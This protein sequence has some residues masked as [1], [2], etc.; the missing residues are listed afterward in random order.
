MRKIKESRD[1]WAAASLLSD[2]T[3]LLPGTTDLA[4]LGY[5][6]NL[7]EMR[8]ACPYPVTTR[9]PGVKEPQRA[10]E[11]GYLARRHLFV[12]PAWYERMVEIPAA[13]QGSPVA[14][15][16]ERTMWRTDVWIDGQSIGSCDSLVTEHRYELG[17]LSAGPHRITVRVDNRLIHNISTITHAY[18]PETQSRWNG[19]IGNLQ[20]EQTTPLYIRSVAAFPS[21]DRRSVKCTVH[22]ANTTP[23]RESGT[24]HV[25]LYPE[26]STEVLAESQLSLGCEPGNSQQD[27]PL[28]LAAPARAWDEFQ[29]AR[30]RAVASWETGEQR[31]ECAVLFG[32]RHIERVG[33]EIHV[34]GQRIFLRGTL[35]CCNY[36]RTGHPPMDVAQ[37]KRVLG[38]VKQYGFN[39]V[40]FH[41]WC[42]PEAAFEAADQLGL[43]LLA[44][45]PAWVDDW[46]VQTATQPKGIG[47]DEDVVAYLRSEMQRISA[48]YGNHPS[49]VMFTIGNEFGITQTDWDCVSKMVLEI[50]Q[51]DPRRLYSGCCARRCLDVDDY[52]ITHRCGDA[53]ARGIGPASTDW[54]FSQAV[55]AS[56]KPVIAHETG[57]RPVFPDYDRLLPKFTG[58]LLPLNLERHRRSL[59][60]HGL[61]HQADEFVRASARFQWTQYKAEHEAMVRTPGLSGYQLLM[62]NDFT[63][64]SEALVGLLDPF[65]ESKGVVSLDEVRTWNAP[66]TLLARFPKYVWTNQESF[67]AQVSI[68]N[69][70]S[71]EL[72]GELS[73]VLTTGAG[74]PVAAGKCQVAGVQPGTVTPVQPI[75]AQ[76]KDLPAATALTLTVQLGDVTNHWNLWSVPDAETAADPAGVVVTRTLDAATIDALA[77]GAK[78]LWLAH[79]V[80]NDRT[81]QT[82][83]ASVYWSA[84]WWGNAFSSLGIVCDPAHPALAQFPNRGH[85]DWV[86]Q[87]LCEDAT[88]IDLTGAP[89]GYRPLVQPV[90]D[91][92]F[93]TL[94]GHVFEAK[95]G[96]GRLLVCGYD[97]TNQ[98]RSA[99]G[100]PPVSPEPYALHVQRRVRT[101]ARTVARLARPAVWRGNA[102]TERRRLSRHLVHVG[103]ILG[104]RGGSLFRQE[105]LGFWR[106]VLRRTWHLYGETRPDRR[107][108]AASEQD[109][110]LLRRLERRKTLPLQHD[111]VLRPCERCCAAPDD[112]SRQTRGR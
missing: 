35:D 82:G 112:R 18:G 1:Q 54:D 89:A 44:E 60:A 51:L 92:H 68:A 15:R 41:T 43:Y 13:W 55:D 57:Q 38:T 96:A 108:C 79:G 86:W 49:F 3:I 106:Q 23:T 50:K 94:L 100:R 70:D 40:R 107:L 78:V 93:N 56:P 19:L 64:Q 26:H 66:T 95:V 20:L 74:V 67:Q 81:A 83:F 69:Y 32:F 90:P 47:H 88:T 105:V 5:A 30:Y 103:S 31:D 42:P 102:Q 61:A 59:I 52:W 16:L 110:L 22:L 14:L 65:G 29:T 27:V 58:P 71:R 24:L 73:W 21:A 25:R 91:F 6:L 39:H 46:G 98:A 4:G 45:T 76:L 53:A 72:S 17:T 8:Y 36:P 97:I 111:L 7:K 75:T 10:D 9:F 62:L 12:G 109:V 34:N 101:A 37:W 48:A 11:Q 77:G 99:A 85:S 84:G 87:E 2:T 104:C 33:K 28:T 80:K 63:G